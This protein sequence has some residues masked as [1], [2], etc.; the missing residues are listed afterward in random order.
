MSTGPITLVPRVPGL[1]PPHCTA[2]LQSIYCPL[3][4]PTASQFSSPR[5]GYQSLFT[6]AFRLPHDIPQTKLIPL[7][8]CSRHKLTGSLRVLQHPRTGHRP[9]GQAQRM[10]RP[11]R[12]GQFVHGREIR[13]RKPEPAVCS[14]RRRRQSIILSRS[15]R[16]FRH[17]RRHG[18]APSFPMIALL[19]S[20][21]L[22]PVSRNE[23]ALF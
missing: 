19:V 22:S 2:Q 17:R 7:V 14:A 10:Q 18:N 15:A 3:S 1:Q 4:R 23:H 8:Q 12:T 13:M 21:T 11:A 6:I 9:A 16:T 5:R 20:A